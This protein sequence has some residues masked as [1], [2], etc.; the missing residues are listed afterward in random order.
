MVKFI[1]SKWF[2]PLKKK[3]YIGKIRYG[4][5]Y[6]YP[7]W[8]NKNIVS[9][10]YQ[11]NNP[12]TIKKVPPMI[13]RTKNW[14]FTKFGYDFWIAIGWPLKFEAID[15]GWKDKYNTPRFEWNPMFQIW[16]FK[17]QFIITWKP[18]FDDIG[19]IDNYWEQLIWT[20]VYCDDDKKKKKQ[21]WPWKSMNNESSWSDEYLK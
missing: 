5:P 20:K 21:T 8:F 4:T 1:T 15:L 12:E 16:F 9:F 19:Q 14:L 7:W 11:K 18:P 6:F 3:Y 17:W 10:R 13:R 2:K